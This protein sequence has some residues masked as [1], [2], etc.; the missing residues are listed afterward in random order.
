MTFAQHALSPSTGDYKVEHEQQLKF[1]GLVEERY[2]VAA[3][4]WFY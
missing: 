1:V 3:K 2:S 4:A